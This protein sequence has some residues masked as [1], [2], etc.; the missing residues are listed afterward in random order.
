MTIQPEP[1]ARIGEELRSNITLRD[2]VA[3]LFRQLRALLVSFVLIL[4]AV[5]IW[6]ALRPAYKAEMKLLVRRGRVDPIVTSQQNAPAQGVRE[7]ITESELNSEVELLNSQDLLRKVVLATGLQTKQGSWPSI[8]GRPS[9]EVAIAMAVRQLGRQ[10]KVEPLKKTDMISVSLESSDPKWAARVLNSLATLYL[11][12]HFQ[13]HRPDGEFTFFDQETEHLRRGLGSA[14][15]RLTDF[16]RDKGVVSA[17]LERD[18]TLQKASELG[19]SLNQTQASIAETKRRIQTLEQQAALIPPRTMTQLRTADNPGLLQQMKSTLLQLELKRTEML[20]KFEPTYR[21]VQDLERQI[22]DTRAAIAGEKN[23]PTRDE[24]TD[25]NSIYEW[26]K[27][28]L[29]K[30]RTDLSGLEA[31][32]IADKMALAKYQEGARDLQQASVVQQ[33]LLR[34][35]KTQEDNYLLYLRKEEEARINDALDRRGI[36]NVA[37]ADPPSVPALPTQSIWHYCLLGV[38][39]AGIGSVGL[40]FVSDFMDPSFRTPDEVV[41]FLDSPVLA[42]IPKNCR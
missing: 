7:E 1:L 12:K 38:L 13:V 37:I 9:E 21:P 40:A 8:L 26:V 30:A 15:S 17:Q 24:T 6:G 32:A 27:S 39:F 4:L 34:T 5:A 28:E 10:I 41:A 25:Q 14:E 19:A 2:V 22:S 35:V 23:A 18:L 33:D 42:S 16:T 11:E 31:R 36:L 20:S 3:V 29:A